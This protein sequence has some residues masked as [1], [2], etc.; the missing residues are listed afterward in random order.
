MG[1]CRTIKPHTPLGEHFERNRLRPYR[2]AAG[3]RPPPT[4]PAHTSWKSR[5]VRDPRDRPNRL[6]TRAAARVEWVV[7]GHAPGV[8]HMSGH[9]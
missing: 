1:R 2:T 9:F 7:L 8:Y 6:Y 4:P 3:S 5:P